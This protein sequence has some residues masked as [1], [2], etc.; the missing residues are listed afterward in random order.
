MRF[1][2]MSELARLFRQHGVE[3]V[4]IKHLSTKQ[5]NEKN[6]IYLGD[7]L[8]SVTNLFPAKIGVRRASESRKKRHSD[9]GEHKLEAEIRLSWIGDDG[10]LYPAP[11][12]R[13]IDY[14]QYPEVRMSGFL[15]GCRNAPDAVRRRKQAQFGRRILA[16]GA[17]SDGRVLGRVLTERDDPVVKVFPDLPTYAPAPVLRV[18]LTHGRIGS[19]PEKLLVTDLTRIAK[20]GWHDSRILKRSVGEAEPFRGSQGAGYTLEALL[21][22]PANADKAPDIYGFELKSYGSS[23]LSLMTPTPDG[24]YQGEHTFREF[25]ERFGRP[26]AKNDGSIRF[27]GTHRFGEINRKTGMGLVMAGYDAATGEFAN[28]PDTISVQLRHMESG[29]VV[30]SWSLEHL[31]NA[32]NAKHAAACYVPSAKCDAPPGEP[33]DARYMYGP[34]ATIGEGTDVWKLLRAI[35]AGSVYYDPADSIYAD[36]RAKVRP[37]WRINTPRLARSLE[38]LYNRVHVVSLEG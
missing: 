15:A 28:D 36:G 29:V 6:Q 21:G 7:G 33:Y 3:T 12:T 13:I 23:R 25:M 35:A 10:E 37:Q 26:G 32:W 34:V 11:G 20:A 22:V 16:L 30:A 31:A 19:S 2:K 14:F 38:P 8:D 27:T 9:A 24:G 18:L 5:D 17:T 4:Y 1:S